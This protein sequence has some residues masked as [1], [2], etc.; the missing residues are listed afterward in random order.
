MSNTELLPKSNLEPAR[1][2]EVFTGS[3][4]RGA[5]TA[6]QKA[7]LAAADPSNTEWQRDLSIIY[8]RV[9]AVLMAQGK[10]DEAVKAYR[11]SLA[12]RERLAAADRSALSLIASSFPISSWGRHPGRL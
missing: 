6:E 8:E 4:R 2:L 7:R 11:D 12:I 9:G 10:R 1:R 5:W 3:G